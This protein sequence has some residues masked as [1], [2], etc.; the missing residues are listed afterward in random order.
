MPDLTQ[1]V[2]A[3]QKEIAALRGLVVELARSKSADSDGWLD[4]KDAA[5]Y[6]DIS[7]GSFDKYR[8]NTSPRLTGYALDGK[9][10]YNK[11]DI[12][13]FIRLYDVKSR[14]LA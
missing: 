14:G 5:K 2:A 12:D 11:R 7:P 9:T 6:M 10:L 3:M 4:A 13:S 8:Y 1:M